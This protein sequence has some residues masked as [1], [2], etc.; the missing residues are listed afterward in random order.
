MGTNP[1]GPAL[2]IHPRIFR[3]P[4]AFS[5]GLEDSGLEYERCQGNSGETPAIFRLTTIANCHIVITDCN[6]RLGEK[7]RH[8]R[9]VEGT[10]R[11][12][13]R[14][15]SR[16]EMAKLIQKH[17]RRRPGWP[18]EAGPICRGSISA[19]LP[20]SWPASVAPGICWSDFAGGIPG[21]QS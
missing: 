17:M 13:D 3:T 11:G 18:A 9:E 16:L 1:C 15:L 7:P 19:P 20:P 12:L 8:P 21:L 4:P 14:E 6:G 10:L 5:D 2:E